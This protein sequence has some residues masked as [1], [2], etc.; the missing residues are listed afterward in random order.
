MPPEH[1]NY[2]TSPNSF[3][4]FSRNKNVIASHC[5]KRKLLPIEFLFIIKMNP[6]QIYSVRIVTQGTL[7]PWF[8][9]TVLLYW[10]VQEVQFIF[11][12][13]AIPE[14]MF[15]NSARE[16]DNALARL[17]WI[18]SILW[19]I[20]TKLQVIVLYIHLLCKNLLFLLYFQAVHA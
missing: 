10:S 14:V 1:L 9:F 15:V 2:T 5:R 11:L 3:P 8:R 7:Q 12:S 16:K 19:S 6:L 17:T 20:L 13:V 18:I 4:L